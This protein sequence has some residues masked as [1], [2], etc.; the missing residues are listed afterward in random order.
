MKTEG[1]IRKDRQAIYFDCICGGSIS[2]IS[3][4]FII[5]RTFEVG[6]FENYV[7]YALGLGFWIFLFIC[8]LFLI[9]EG[10]HTYFLEKKHP[11]GIPSK[12]PA[13]APVFS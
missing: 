9:Y 10:I 7:T 5:I 11:E 1:D 4:T 6:I 13:K 2:I 3:I 8:S 12:K